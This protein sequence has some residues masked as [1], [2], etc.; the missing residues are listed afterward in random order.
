[1]TANAA[2]AEIKAL[3]HKVSALLKKAQNQARNLEFT[4]I[5]KLDDEA[6]IAEQKYPGAYLIEIRVDCKRFKTIEAWVTFFKANWDNDTPGMHFTPGIKAR[7]VAKHK[8]LRAWM[9]F[10]LGIRK[11]FVADRVKQHINLRP[12]ANTGGLKLKSRKK[13]KLSDFRL[14]TIELRLREYDAIMPKLERAL[15]DSLNPIAGN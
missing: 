15:Q 6:K 2:M 1:M 14:S 11:T 10:Y 5:C 8:R 9:P 3:D 13:V 4:R 7:R 12:K